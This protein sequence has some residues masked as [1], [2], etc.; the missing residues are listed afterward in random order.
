[1]VLFLFRLPGRFGDWCDAITVR[2]AEA[3]LGLVAGISPGTP[4]ELATAL[5]NPPAPNLLVNG[6]QPGAWLRRMLLTTHKPFILALD[7]PET[8]VSELASRYGLAVSDATRR[9][10]C[11]CAS[12]VPCLRL[13]GALVLR[14]DRHWH[15]PLLTAGEM[16]RHLGIA[17]DPGEIERIVAE[18]AAAGLG[19][20][21][22]DAG[23]LDEPGLAIVKGA[24]SAYSDHFSGAS[25]DRITWA[26]E[27]FMIDGQQPATEAVDV[28]GR[29]RALIYGPYITLPPGNWLAEVVL[30]FS[31][32][33][34]DV[35]FVVDILSAGSQL[36]VTSIRPPERGVFPIDL[37]FTIGEEND[38]PVE[39]RVVNE[40]AAFDG[41]VMLG[42]V[43]LSLQHDRSNAAIELLKTEL[44][45]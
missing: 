40:R 32:E 42:H 4:E 26:R 28:T 44:G 33:A 25:L 5:V 13:P 27:L 22:S 37:S 34:T 43:T 16:A 14:A 17:I 15:E 30:G 18:V 24:L 36:S 39:F 41:R 19:P 23:Q 11:S 3:A 21:A 8:T 31:Q 1:M 7:E 29:V 20:E 12:I 45:L 10:G 35:N 38:R 2:I 9:V 6:D